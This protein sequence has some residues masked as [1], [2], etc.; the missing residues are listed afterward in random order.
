LEET[1]A[2][3]V[4][5]DLE[6]ARFNMV[7][8]QVRPWLV[9]DQRIL[10]L[11]AQVPR[12]DFVPLQYRNLAFA[13]VSLPLGHGEVMMSPKVEARLLQALDVKHSD[14]VL[15]VGTGSGYLTA[16]L[17]RQA[18]QVYSVE[19]AQDLST[20]AKTKLSAHNVNNVILEVG[21]AATGWAQHAPYEVVALTGSLPILPE[22][23]LQSLAIG[24]RL[25]VILGQSP[26]ME[27][28]LITRVDTQSWAE[29]S[30]FETDLPALRNARQPQQF[31]F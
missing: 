27:A 30:L 24:G 15:E 26:V 19:I 6:Q 14:R 16:L 23:F 13:D 1:V 9:L 22:G 7:E 5:I 28:R 3:M 12:E 17:A 8:Q 21:D 10:D 2:I 20:S 4:E 31:L 18:N 11:I 29:E 25:F